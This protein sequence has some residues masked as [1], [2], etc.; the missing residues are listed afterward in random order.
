MRNILKKTAPPGPGSGKK[1][2]ILIKNEKSSRPNMILDDPEVQFW[3]QD[4]DR[5]LELICE[6]H[7]KTKRL[8]KIRLK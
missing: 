4:K 5:Y 1:N 2:H 3:I 6:S 7:R 8:G